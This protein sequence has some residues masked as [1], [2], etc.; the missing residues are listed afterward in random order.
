MIHILNNRKFISYAYCLFH[1]VKNIGRD[2][3]SAPV[4][5]EVYTSGI[6]YRDTKEVVDTSKKGLEAYAKANNL[7]IG[8]FN[9]GPRDADYSKLKKPLRVMVTS[10][11][12][13]H[14]YVAKKTIEGNPSINTTYKKGFLTYEDNLARRIYRTVEELKNNISEK[15]SKKY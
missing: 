11:F 6:I 4:N 14:A 5:G 15:K 12:A 7:N 8:F 1:V 9:P 2:I 10:E 3:K 13:N